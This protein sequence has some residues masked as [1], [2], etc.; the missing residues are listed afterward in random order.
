[1]EAL[2]RRSLA[3]IRSIID[4]AKQQTIETGGRIDYPVN[5]AVA[6][7]GGLLRGTGFIGAMPSSGRAGATEAAAREAPHGA[8][9]VP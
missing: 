3:V 2:G 4:G 7:G 1:M 5:S 8:R 9:R 6:R